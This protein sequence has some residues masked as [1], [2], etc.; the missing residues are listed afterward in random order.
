MQKREILEHDD[1]NG[2]ENDLSTTSDDSIA[3]RAISATEENLRLRVEV[4]NLEAQLAAF[5]S[6][7]EAAQVETHA[8]GE[9]AEQQLRDA[10]RELDVTKQ[11]RQQARAEADRLTATWHSPE[12]FQEEA[13]K[14]EAARN[15]LKAVKDDAQRK[16]N[17]LAAVKAEKQ[18]REG[19]LQQETQAVARLETE[20]QLAREDARKKDLQ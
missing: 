2:D 14:A 12:A 1:Q 15:A 5:R 9:R 10:L 7:A 13:A 17:A 8:L 16:A 3:A 4:K 11:E 20:L 19:Q 6:R 18:N